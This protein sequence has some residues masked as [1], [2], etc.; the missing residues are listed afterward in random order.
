MVVWRLMT[1]HERPED[2]LRWAKTSQ[3]LAIGWGRIG[4]LM[5][6]HHTSPESIREAIR[7]AYPGVRNASCGGQSLWEFWRAMKPDDR[8]ILST[9]RREAVMRVT[10]PYQFVPESQ[11]PPAE[12]YQHQRQAE[13]LELDADELWARA[14]G[15]ADGYNRY[16]PLVRCGREIANRVEA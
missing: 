5:A 13:L 10:G 1:H 11:Q 9:G 8:V 2:M 4:D 7:E 6:H 14:G 12:G 16:C 15:M 3:R